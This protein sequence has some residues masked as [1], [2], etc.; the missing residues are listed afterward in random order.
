MTETILVPFAGDGVGVGQ[1]TW[2]QRNIWRMMQMLGTPEMVGGTMPLEEG[3]TVE[4]IVHLLSFIMSRHQSLRTRIRVEADGTPVQILHDSGEAALEIHDIAGTDNPAR[5]AETIRQRFE[6]APF[7]IEHE[8][9]V[10]M[11]VVRQDQIPV[12]FAVM[13]PHMV[14]DGY[15]FEALTEDLANLNRGTGEHLAPRQGIQPMELAVL[16]QTPAERRRSDQAMHYWEQLLR[17]VP[18]RRFHEAADKREP[19]WWDGIY[20]SPAAFKAL[21]VLADRVRVHTGPILMAAYGVAIAKV[22]GIA[23]SVIRTLVS[24][25]FR[26]GFTESVSVLVQPGLCT[27]DVDGYTFEEIAR[28]TFRSQLAASKHGYYDPRDL[29]ALIERINSERGVELDL[30][31]Y[32]NDRRRALARMPSGPLPTIAEITEAL[33]QSRWEWGVR[34]DNPDAKAYLNV[35]SKPDTLN[36]DLRVDTHA[37]SPL[38]LLAVL[39]QFE[40]TLISAVLD[41][42]AVIRV[43]TVALVCSS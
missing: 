2:A 36:Y 1:L 28:R 31:C 40:N 16:Q 43:P 29:W 39:R 26:P 27:I 14:I 24:N 30:M 21:R 13:Y 41:P 23:P 33:P 4:H 37:L 7:D 3:T 9:P 25:R 6:T 10:R 8:W 32:F 12:Y 22:T 42:E 15:G 5:V 17:S 18:A 35:N 19:R 34:T 20:D 38:E 11:A